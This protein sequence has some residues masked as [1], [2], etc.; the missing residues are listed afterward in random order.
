MLDL[1]G[2]SGSGRALL[3]LAIALLIGGLVTGFLSGLLGIGGGGI[4]API[5]YEVFGIIGVDPAVRMHCAVGTALAVMIPTSIRSF[6][7]HKARGGVDMEA[8]RRLGVGVVAGVVIGALVASVSP[9]TLLKWVWVGFATVMS[10]KLVFGKEQW[11]LGEQLPNAPLTEL[12]GAFVGVI[13]TLLS[14]GGGAFINTF[15]TLYGRTIQTAVGTA[16]GIGPLIAIPGTIGFLW[17]GLGVAGRPELSLG[18]VNLVGFVLVGATSVLAAPWG[19][20][21]AHGVSRRALELAFAAMLSTIGLR[22]LWTL[23]FE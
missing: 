19:V 2:A 4:V 11:R 7:A 16:S 6:M 22:F 18:Y 13:S 23:L 3:L 20:R 9:G 5:L 1:A 17:A 21:L 8:W 14:I 10:L 15:M 12:Y